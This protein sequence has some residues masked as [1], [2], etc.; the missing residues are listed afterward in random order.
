M[1]PNNPVNRAFDDTELYFPEYLTEV[2]QMGHL[3]G[4]KITNPIYNGLTP[5]ELRAL[6][7]YNP[8]ELIRSHP[9]SGYRYFL[10]SVP[11]LQGVI[12]SWPYHEVGHRFPIWGRPL[13]RYWEL[14]TTRESE[15]TR[16]T[17]L[18]ITLRLRP[19]SDKRHL[20]TLWDWT[21]Y[22]PRL[23][24]CPDREGSPPTTFKGLL[25]NLHLHQECYIVRHM[26][27]DDLCVFIPPTSLPPVKSSS[28][29]LTRVF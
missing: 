29:P 26:E 15:P 7:I 2:L 17:S 25:R 10:V 23:D 16:A 21:L 12:D 11:D 22:S 5:E 8:E 13:G 28:G 20:Y 19:T 14:V 18:L 4:S 27:P 3:V 24:L 1:Y 6:M 9:E